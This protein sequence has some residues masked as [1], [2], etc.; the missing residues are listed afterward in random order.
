MERCD[1]WNMTIRSGLGSG[2]VAL[3]AKQRFLSYVSG[4]K[5]STAIARINYSS[6]TTYDNMPG[7]DRCIAVV[8]A[9]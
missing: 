1:E 9:M 4:W 5:D 6:S 2:I 7:T 3:R 8:S